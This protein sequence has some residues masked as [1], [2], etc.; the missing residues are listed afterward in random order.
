[1]SHCGDLP[2]LNEIPCVPKLGRK[3]R[4]KSAV[5]R[6]A[7]KLCEWLRWN[8]VQAGITGRQIVGTLLPVF[9]F[10]NEI[11]GDIAR[12][13]ALLLALF[14]AL[15]AAGQLEVQTIVQRSVQANDKDWQAAPAYSYFERDVQ[16]EG[17]RTSEV[18][19]IMG[20]SYY[21]LVA[22]DGK[23]LTPGEKAKEQQKLEK[24]TA[25]RCGE[26]KQEREERIAKYERERRRDHLL[27][28]EMTKAFDFELVGEQR[29]GPF[30]VYVLKATPRPG[31]QPSN[32]ETKVLT[33]MQG[34]LWIDKQTFH[35]VKVEAE[36]IHP[37]SILGFLAR[38]EPGTRFEL[39]NAPVDSRIWLPEHFAMKSRARILHL[40]TSK[41]QEDETYFDY[42]QAVRNEAAS[43]CTGHVYTP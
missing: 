40:Y 35:W 27:M 26:S 16:G 15:P 37:V 18:T 43:A 32:K 4:L 10:K 21:R 11:S 3:Y 42:H 13:F 31:Y 23:P 22:V 7:T 25:Q 20:S 9:E 28:D 14:T 34:E 1:M 8:R 29:S 38:V 6:L 30:D 39:E 2:L 41:N 17:T 36:V 19:M 24:I 5:V 33:G 12:C